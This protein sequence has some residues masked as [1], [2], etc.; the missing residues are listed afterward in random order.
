VQIVC[1]CNAGGKMHVCR[2]CVNVMQVERCMSAERMKLAVM[3]AVS[4][5]SAFTHTTDSVP[6]SDTIL[7]PADMPFVANT[8][9]RRGALGAG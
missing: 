6:P 7:R 8:G 5:V 2:L 4:P 9:R 1:E 3:Q